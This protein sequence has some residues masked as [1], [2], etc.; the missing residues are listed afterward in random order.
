MERLARLLNARAYRHRS[1][2]VLTVD[3][4]A[5]VTQHQNSIWLSHINSG[6][7]IFGSGRRGIYTF[8]RISEYPFEEMRK[9][10]KDD[11]IVEL[12]VDYVVKDISKLVIRVE[13]W[14]GQNPI[15]TI[16]EREI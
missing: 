11:A 2:T 7:A 13:E 4:R 16:W 8:K 5:L 1:H 14:T 12:A 6:S 9:K 10:K 3:T 15:Q